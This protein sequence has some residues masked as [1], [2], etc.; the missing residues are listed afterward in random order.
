MSWE[1]RPGN[2][3]AINGAKW[4]FLDGTLTLEPSQM[5]IGEAETRRFT[6]TID[7]LD[8]AMRELVRGR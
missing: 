7:G 5:K 8:K 6:L 3:L 2:V 4:P 1:L